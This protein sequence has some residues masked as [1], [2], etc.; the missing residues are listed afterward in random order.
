MQSIL[1]DEKKLTLDV[2]HYS[3]DPAAVFCFLTVSNPPFM[4]LLISLKV[5]YRHVTVPP[6]DLYNYIY[7]G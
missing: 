5:Q 6:F 4:G 2:L 3:F 1:F 7:C